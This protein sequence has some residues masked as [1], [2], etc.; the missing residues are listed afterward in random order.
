MAMK[1]DRRAF[2]KTSAAMAVAVSMTGL[3][4]GCSEGD[5]YGE[6]VGLGKTAELQGM[7]MRVDSLGTLYDSATGS[8]YMVP[9]VRLTN[10]GALPIEVAPEKGSFSIIL[11]NRTEMAVN[12][13]TMKHIRESQPL[14]PLQEQVL[15]HNK[16]VKG[17]VCA[18]GSGVS[19]VD[20]VYVVYY[21]TASCRTTYLRCKIYSNEFSLLLGL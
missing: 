5:L 19:R 1:I 16:T 20:Y 13:N 3:L 17:D 18:C 10:N 14:S 15:T 11:P 7:Q 21:P 2:L 9:S 6:A 8:F 12:Q 4:G